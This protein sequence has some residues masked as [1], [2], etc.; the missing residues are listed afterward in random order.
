MI[1]RNYYLPIELKVIHKNFINQIVEEVINMPVAKVEIVDIDETVYELTSCSGFSISLKRDTPLSEF[2][3][4]LDQAN[5]WN[6]RTTDYTDLLKPDVRK[7]IK[8]YFGQTIDGEIEYVQ[9][10]TGIPI[11]M[12]ESYKH[13]NTIMISIAG[14]NLAHLL[15]REVGTYSSTVY[16]GTSKE[17]IEYWCDQAGVTYSL[18]YTDTVT[19]NGIAIGYNSALIGI[20]DILE[21]LG[22]DVESYF[23]PTGQ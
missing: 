19:F 5:L 17:L 21:V 7:R 13:G 15:H 8:I 1:T 9:M 22:P 11:A 2:T 23:S 10:F 12:P 4:S 3:V 14:K 16:S 18:G 6:I 20:L